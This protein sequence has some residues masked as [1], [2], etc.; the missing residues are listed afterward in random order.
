MAAG[1][2]VVRYP[3]PVAAARCVDV[4]DGRGFAGRTLKAF[5][6]DGSKQYGQLPPWQPVTSSALSIYLEAVSTPC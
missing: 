5:F 2:I 1:P 3:D 4:M 6:Y